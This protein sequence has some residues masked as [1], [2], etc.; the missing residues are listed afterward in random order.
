MEILTSNPFTGSYK[1]KI[2]RTYYNEDNLRKLL[3][4]S[5]DSKAFYEYEIEP[6]VAVYPNAD[7]IDILLNESKPITLRLYIYILNNCV[8]EDEDYIELDFKRVQAYMN[9]SRN[10]L[11]LAIDQLRDFRFIAPGKGR[12]NYWLNTHLAFK[13]NRVDYLNKVHSDSLKIVKTTS[14]YL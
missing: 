2:I 14:Q 3:D 12:G 8:K 1:V 7:F 13:G 6:K 10:N 11:Y 9:T 5:T 4:T